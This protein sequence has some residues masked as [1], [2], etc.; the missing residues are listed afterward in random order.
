MFEKKSSPF[1]TKNI[2]QYSIV[3][4]HHK[5]ILRVP[6]DAEISP[7][8][9]RS[10]EDVDAAN[11]SSTFPI[12][13][14]IKK[15]KLMVAHESQ[16]ITGLANRVQALETERSASVSATKRLAFSS[17]YPSRSIHGQLEWI[18]TMSGQQKFREF[19]LPQINIKSYIKFLDNADT[20]NLPDFLR[21]LIVIF[22]PGGSPYRLSRLSA[23]AR[24]CI[25]NAFLHFWGS[26]GIDV[27]PEYY[28]RIEARIGSQ[29]QFLNTSKTKHQQVIK[30]VD[31]KE[32]DEKEAEIDE[33]EEVEEK[34]E[35]DTAEAENLGF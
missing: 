27:E 7:S 30:S 20:K 31:E 12:V 1:E 15:L 10:V 9:R 8:V 13:T 28:A 23:E 32:G 18:M 11:T 34:R 26:V 4:G 22:T 2:S 16:L 19:L 5:G 29:T 25:I 21:Q 33:D 6:R 3:Q 14:E 17:R 35:K 24:H